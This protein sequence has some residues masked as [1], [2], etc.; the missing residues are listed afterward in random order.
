MALLTTSSIRALIASALLGLLPTTAHALGIGA[1]SFGASIGG[2][3][4]GPI[5]ISTEAEILS[6][7][8][9]NLLETTLVVENHGSEPVRV[10]LLGRVVWPDGSS[11]I[12]R[13]GPPVAIDANGAFL[14]SALSPIPEDAGTGTGTF[15]ATAFVGPVGHGGRAAFAGPL[16]ARDSSTFELF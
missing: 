12:L 16:I 8:L 1:A 14:L 2:P 11:Q 3:V 13:Y 9:G 7:P 4:A 6:S 15:T 5:E 10:F